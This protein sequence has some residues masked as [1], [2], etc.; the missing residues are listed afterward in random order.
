MAPTPCAGRLA[1]R[2]ARRPPGT[3][4]VRNAATPTTDLNLA[5]PA[6]TH[7]APAGAIVWDARLRVARWDQ[8]A[9]AVF[10]YA[11][12]DVIG[13]DAFELLAGSAGAAAAN[14]FVARMVARRAGGQIPLHAWTKAGRLIKCQ[15]TMAP[16]FDAQGA[17]EGFAAA[18]AVPPPP[19]IAGTDSATGLASEQLFLDRIECAIAVARRCAHAVAVVAIGSDPESAR[20]KSPPSGAAGSGIA[21]LAHRLG[22]VMRAADSLALLDCDTLG[23]LLVPVDG[24]AGALHAAHRLERACAGSGRSAERPAMRFGIALFPEDGHDA[25]SLV[26]AALDALT[27]ARGHERDVLRTAHRARASTAQELRRALDRG[28]IELHFEPEMA[29]RDGSLCG[30]R[31]LPTW[32]RPSGLVYAPA[33]EALARGEGFVPE[34]CSWIVHAACAALQQWAGEGVCVPHVRIDIPE[35]YAQQRLVDDV[36]QALCDSDVDPGMLELG[37]SP[38]RSGENIT[39]VAWLLEALK[40]LGVRRSFSEIGLT[41]GQFDAFRSLGLDSVGVDEGLVRGSM[42]DAASATAVRAIVEIAHAMDVAVVAAGVDTAD[43]ATFL[44][45][46]RCD[47]ARGAFAGAAHPRTAFGREVGRG[48]GFSA[49]TTT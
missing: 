22:P 39:S 3:A 8:A 31:A 38:P 2:V 45:S 10:G 35:E 27:E 33:L 7:G 49:R 37:F 16:L 18:V 44:R 5:L 34:L 47:S 29:L 25:P 32:R 42:E 43:Q 1:T 30:A 46:A 26:A 28:Q 21:L 23:A 40:P 14:D 24:E 6:R 11:A 13:K 20:R 15:L 12:C 4:H 36:A 41:F 19:E 9:E 48:L 17:I